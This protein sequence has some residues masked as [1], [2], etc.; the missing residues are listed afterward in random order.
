ME[1]ITKKQFLDNIIVKM[2][3]HINGEDLRIMEDIITAE[4]VYV[5]MDK[6]S[7]LP[8]LYRDDIDQRNQYIIQ[9]F[10]VKKRIKENTKEGYLR[11]VRK[12]AAL[13]HK[14]LTSMDE[15]DI[16]YY[17]SWYEHKDGKK[18]QATTYNNERRFLS[19]FFT[20]MRKEKLIPENPVEAIEPRRV[21]KKPI[22]YFQAEELIKLR[23]ACETPRDRALIEVLRS[24]GARVGELV[25]IT[26]DQ[27]DWTTG[28]ILILSE[29]SDRYR[30]LYL[31]DD[32]RHYLKDY[33]EGRAIVSPYVFAQSRAPHNKMHTCGIRMAIKSIAK[34][35]GVEGRVYPHKW[36]KTLGMN[37]K[38]KGVDIGV[39][40]EIMGHANPAV[41]AE[42]YAQSTPE[43]LRNVRRMAS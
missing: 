32:A 31:D 42:Y 34:K 38:N 18:I 33:L 20:W 22:D 28:D 8:E 12:L 29:K 7:T 2:S 26:T 1:N 16:S 30:T 6:I 35:A 43:T 13:I 11:A 17:L 15:T 39:I 36:R 14:P 4:L 27:I 5:N 19:A 41:T 3:G 9:L 40:Q 10:S 24:T 37:L 23:D 25:E 21:I